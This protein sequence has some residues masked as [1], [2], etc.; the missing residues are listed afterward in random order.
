M[1]FLCSKLCFLRKESENQVI[2]ASKLVIQIEPEI[3]LR[4]LEIWT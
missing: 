3:E 2:V 1:P 4:S